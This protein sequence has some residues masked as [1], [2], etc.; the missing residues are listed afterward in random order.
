MS[1]SVVTA[2]FLTVSFM[3]VSFMT[4]FFVT[5]SFVKASF[6]TV[7]VRSWLK[8]L[9]TKGMFVSSICAVTLL[10][11][12]QTPDQGEKTPD[13]PV[14]NAETTLTGALDSAIDFGGPTL[15]KTKGL[16]EQREAGTAAARLIAEA[17]SSNLLSYK[18]HQLFNAAHLLLATGEPIEVELFQRLVEASRPIAGQLGWQ[19]AARRPSPALADAIE[20]VLGKSLIEGNEKQLL[21]PEMGQALI[22]NRL[23][24]SYTWARLGLMEKGSEEFANAMIHL[25]ANQASADFLD[26][27]AR[28]PAAE[29]RQLTLTSVN[30]YTCLIILKHLKA[31][32]PPAAHSS[33]DHLFLYAVSRNPAL[34]ELGRNV[35][36]GLLPEH[37]DHLALLLARHEAWVQM[38]FLENVRRQLTPQLGLLLGELKTVTA[39][40]AV[41]DEINQIRL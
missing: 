23:Q 11:G 36:E 22:A 1:M 39:Q 9:M 18:K 5:V 7:S 10:P 14:I 24:S 41:V 31:L 32:P 35:I 34:S 29:L 17:I 3:T 2:S 20:D 4:V 16:I 38:A 30:L 12:C 27:L 15:A 21:V 25:D 26:Y 33:L 37:K 19:L 6:T 13:L 8:N 40:R 28:A